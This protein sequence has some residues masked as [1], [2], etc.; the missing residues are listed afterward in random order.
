[1]RMNTGQRQGK[2]RAQAGRLQFRPVVSGSCS[3][4]GRKEE[5]AEPVGPDS[6]HSLVESGFYSLGCWN[7]GF[8][9]SLIPH[10]FSFK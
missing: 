10:L 4:L 2:L 9:C 8:F 3:S 6:E 7:P 1:M 5:T